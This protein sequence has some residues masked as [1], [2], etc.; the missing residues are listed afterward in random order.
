MGITLDKP[1]S[2]EMYLFLMFSQ[3]T[4]SVWWEKEVE[5]G[6]YYTNPK[7]NEDL[8]EKPSTGIILPISIYQVI[9]SHV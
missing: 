9:D 1:E 7:T 4:D 8:W 3:F 5:A 6:T 2:S